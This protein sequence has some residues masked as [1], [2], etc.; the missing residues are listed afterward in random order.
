MKLISPTLFMALIVLLLSSCS[1]PESEDLKFE[2]F[3]K[4]YLAQLLER[5]PE[6][7][8][9]LGDHRFDRRMNDYSL[10]GI[11]AELKAQ[12]EALDKA[13]QIHVEKLSPTNQIDFK[14]LA[15]N[16]EF[17]IFQIESVREY[18]WDTQFYNIGKAIYSLTAREFAPLKD[19]LESVSARLKLIPGVLEQAKTNLKNPPRIFTETSIL[20]NKGNIS[21]IQ[22]ELNTLLEQVPELKAGFAPAQQ[23][24]V[25]ALE[26]YGNWLE[27]DLL[28]R[29]NG[30]FRLGEEKFR[31][32]LR[33]TLESDQTLEELMQQ[34]QRELVASQ[35]ALYETSLPLYQKFFPKLAASAAKGDRKKVIKAVLDKLAESRPNNETIVGLAKQDLQSATEFVRQ[36]QLVSIPEEPVKIIVMPE[37]QRGV[38]VAYCDSPGPLEKNGETF[39]S[40]SPTPADWPKSRV[41]SFFREYNN[42]MLQNLTVHEAMPGHYL[43]IA[44][45]NKFRAPTMIRAIFSSGPF[46]EGWATYAEQL[47]AEKGYGGAE[48]KVQQLKMRLR[49][50]INAII[51]QKIHTAGMTEKEA[52]DLMMNEGFQEEGEA[53]GKWRRACLSSTQLSTYFVGNVGVNEIRNAYEKK[54]GPIQD[55][56]AFHDKMLSFGSPAPKYVKELMG[57]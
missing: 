15:N 41:E 48:V 16:I 29:S 24:A 18:E 35:T 39:Y 8:T 25:A 23:E 49:L 52:M 37:F 47:M 10:A 6:L 38:A 45:S 56:K 17:M 34:A 5:N 12:Q 1:S 33:F 22:N 43:Q 30:D 32:K 20:Q 44:Q 54:N 27:K 13:R 26:A 53:A 28:T 14:I 9:L 42:E 11:Q 21:L 40:I 31:K 50:I 3:A 57:L 19:R 4:S 36:Q 46:V 7:A 55:W 51:D 2:N